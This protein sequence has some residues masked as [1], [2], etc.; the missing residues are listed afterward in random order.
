MA[1]NRYGNHFESSEE[2]ESSEDD[3][4]FFVKNEESSKLTKTKSMQKTYDDF[5]DGNSFRNGGEIL[6]GKQ[7][8]RDL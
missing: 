5:G 8:Q 3:P 2:Q 7:A 4:A 6:S 1:K